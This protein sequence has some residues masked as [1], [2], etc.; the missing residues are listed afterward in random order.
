MTARPTPEVSIV[1]PSYN[2]PEAIERLFRSITL[3][4]GFEPSGL[5]VILVTDGYPELEDRLVAILAEHQISATVIK[6]DSRK[7][8]SASRNLG[9]AQ[10]RGDLLLFV[11]DDNEF[12]GRTVRTLSDVF[13]DPSIVF[14]GPVMYYGDHRDEL[15]CAGLRR[16]AFL[17][18][19]RWI[20]AIENPAP[21][22]IATDDLP[23]CFMVRRAQFSAVS[24]FDEINFPQMFEE[25]DLAQ[26][27]KELGGGCAACVPSSHTWHHIGAEAAHRRYHLK[28][29]VDAYG[30][31]HHRRAY[32]ARHG[33]PL[34]R[35]VD[36]IGGSYLFVPAYLWALRTAPK[37]TRLS[38]AKAYLTGLHS[39]GPAPTRPAH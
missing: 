12:D 31:A 20:R 27:L 7:L 37:N 33:T 30:L 39:R 6:P 8:V 13:A 29:P 25:A 2:R 3:S 4:E 15:W 26:R 17:A 14:A 24:G 36:R 23:N 28:T 1:V 10:A 11:D 16:S 22:T 5:E 38:L 18:R 19:T 21:A 35:W 9:A 32:L 34:Q